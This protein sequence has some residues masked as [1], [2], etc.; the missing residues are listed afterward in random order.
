MVKKKI[1]FY[2]LYLWGFVVGM[3][4]FIEICVVCF[5]GGIVGFIKS[6]NILVMIIKIL[7]IIIDKCKLVIIICKMYIIIIII[8]RVVYY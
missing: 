4:G 7:I 1:F 3:S 6:S 5:I 8:E 2:F